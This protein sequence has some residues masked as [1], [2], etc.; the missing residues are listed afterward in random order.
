MKFPE[1]CPE[2]TP[3]KTVQEKVHSVVRNRQQI[4]DLIGHI[5]LEFKP[6]IKVIPP[7]IMLEV[8]EIECDGVGETQDQESDGYADEHHGQLE[9]HHLLASSSV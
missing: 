2:Q 3:T 4:A 6:R 7:Q 8:V 5:Q 9:V 1:P